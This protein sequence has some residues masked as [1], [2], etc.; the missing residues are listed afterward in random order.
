MINDAARKVIE[1]SALA[2][3]TT[4]NADGSP[5][6]TLAWTGMDGDEIVIGTLVDQKKLANMRRDPR[7]VL[8]F[9]TGVRNDFG[10]D[11]YLVVY[12]RATIVEGG[13]PEVLRRLTPTYL[14]KGVSFPPPNSPPGHVTRITVD[15]IG[16]MGPWSA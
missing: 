14:G 3:L 2:H 15:R 7:V 9:E 10:L 4:I 13:A 12:G 5:H 8:S 11:E 16:G 1:S 6:V